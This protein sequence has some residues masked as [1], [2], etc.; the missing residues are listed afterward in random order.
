MIAKKEIYCGRSLMAII[1]MNGA[2]SRQLDSTVNLIHKSLFEKEE[3][4]VYTFS[5]SFIMRSPEKEGSTT[6]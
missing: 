6:K 3:I 4:T 2:L 1:L 5:A